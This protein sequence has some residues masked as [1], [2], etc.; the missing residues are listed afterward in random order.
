ME[1]NEMSGSSFDVDHSLCGN[2]ILA[3]YEEGIVD[4]LLPTYLDILDTIVYIGK[5]SSAIIGKYLQTGEL[6]A[7]GMFSEID[8]LPFSA[9]ELRDTVTGV[10]YDLFVRL[11]CLIV[12]ARC[13]KRRLSGRDLLGVKARQGS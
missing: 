7:K 2:F 12:M 8:E 11:L 13:N 3:L 1:G 5:C 4:V 9:L 10:F 6:P